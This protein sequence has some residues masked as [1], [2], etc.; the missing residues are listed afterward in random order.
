MIVRLVRG[1]LAPAHTRTVPPFARSETPNGPP[2]V[3]RGPVR[4]GDQ[5]AAVVSARFVRI[6]ARCLR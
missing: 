5:P 4:G 1:V 3:R 2:P 6:L